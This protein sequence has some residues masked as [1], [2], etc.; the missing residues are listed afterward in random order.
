MGGDAGRNVQ[1]YVWD[2]TLDL[3][4]SFDVFRVEMIRGLLC[5]KAWNFPIQ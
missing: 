2:I 4:E 3:S 1:S 5:T